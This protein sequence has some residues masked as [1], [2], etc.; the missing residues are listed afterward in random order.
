[1][2]H[3]DPWIVGMLWEIDHRDEMGRVAKARLARR[4]AE[5]QAT[6]ASLS[7]ARPGSSLLRRL[8]S[9]FADGARLRLR[10]SGAKVS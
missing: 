10:G 7:A 2:R 6:Q 1:M 4:A 5:W 3:Y 8:V 9:S